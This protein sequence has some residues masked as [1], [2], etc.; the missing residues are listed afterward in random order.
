M[1]SVHHGFWQNFISLLVV[2]VGSADGSFTMKSL[3][4][5]CWLPRGAPSV[6]LCTCPSRARLYGMGWYGKAERLS[7]LG[8][9]GLLLQQCDIAHN[10][11]GD[12]EPWG[13]L[14][15]FWWCGH[16]HTY[17]T[18]LDQPASFMLQVSLLTSAPKLVHIFQVV[19]PLRLPDTS[20]VKR[21]YSGRKASPIHRRCWLL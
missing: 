6:L 18:A 17:A 16:Q 5:L 2:H 15:C 9:A 4:R 21:G 19:G 13:W 14:A 8:A 12:C 10:Q 11:H 3:E 7:A 20:L 1:D